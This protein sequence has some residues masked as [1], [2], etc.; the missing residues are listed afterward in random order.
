MD[1]ATAFLR[2]GGTLKMTPDG[3]RSWH[4]V[5]ATVPAGTP[6][7]LFAGPMG[8]MVNGHDFSYTADSGRRWMAR[9]VPFPASVVGFS[10]P[11]EDAGYVIGDHGMVYRYRVVPFDYAVPNMLVIPPMSGLGSR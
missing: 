4:D 6:K 8:W 7:I 5:P 1:T 10:V 2:A 3:G 11:A 9:T